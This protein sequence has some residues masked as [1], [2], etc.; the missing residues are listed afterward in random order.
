MSFESEN[1][2][3]Q[4]LVVRLS[5]NHLSKTPQKRES[6]ALG[7]IFFF[8][9]HERISKKKYKLDI[10]RAYVHVHWGFLL[11]FIRVD[12]L[13]SLDCH[14]CLDICSSQSLFN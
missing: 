1:R 12:E 9:L 11:C 6:C 10:K 5:T 4:K 2:P 7:T 13:E 14:M 8:R 3:L